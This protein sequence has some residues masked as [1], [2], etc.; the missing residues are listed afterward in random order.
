MKN[1]ILISLLLFTMFSSVFALE[2]KPKLEIVKQASDVK[3]LDNNQGNLSEKIISSNLENGEVT[4]ELKLE[5]K[6][7]NTTENT[8]KYE[9][10]EIYIMIPEVSS[11]ESRKKY[12]DYVESL[13]TK[14]FNKSNK[15]KIGIIGITGT[16]DGKVNGDNSN[17]EII[18][19]PTNNLLQIKNSLNEINPDNNNYYINLQAAI[20]LAS[21]NYSNNVNKILVSLYDGV[22]VIANGYPAT[23][24]FQSQST[25]LQTLNQ[26]YNSMSTEIANEILKLKNSNI[27]FV[28]LRPNDTSYNITYYRTDNN[29][30]IVDFDGSPY[31]QKIYGTK[32]N[33]TYGIMYEYTEENLD[34]VVNESIY[35]AVINLLDL[36]MNNIELQTYFTEDIMNNFDYSF[37]SKS[38][39][40]VSNIKDNKIVWSI[41]KLDT[42]GVAT[43]QYKL[44]VKNITDETLLNKIFKTNE[45]VDISYNIDKTYTDSLTSSPQVR[46]V[47]EETNKSEEN[48]PTDVPSNSNNNKDNV[49]NPETGDNIIIYVILGL[50]LISGS[51]VTYKKV[52]EK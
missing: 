17:A 28:L 37:V 48:I 13:S 12:L 3:S 11:E 1:K 8:E 23:V 42:N 19:G 49:V 44:K 36:P 22:P 21:E 15:V 34:T 9:N 26:R 50:L 40:T 18:I 35:N 20:R 52:V 43:L 47:V 41:D 46:F 7:A 33:P 4:I 45:R 2:F 31:V 27:K 10:T 16:T 39:G 38:I 14:I 32:D 25:V 6:K 24:N 51:I 29:E 5:N 30:K